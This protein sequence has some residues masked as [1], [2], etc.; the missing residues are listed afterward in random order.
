MYPIFNAE[1]ASVADISVISRLSVHR[2][3]K[4]NG[5]EDWTPSNFALHKDAEGM[6]QFVEALQEIHRNGKSMLHTY[7]GKCYKHLRTDEG[8]ALLNAA[9]RELRLR[10]AHQEMGEAESTFSANVR[11]AHFHNTSVKVLKSNSPSPSLRFRADTTS[12]RSESQALSPS[13]SDFPRSAEVA[14]PTELSSIASSTQT[15]EAKTLKNQTLLKKPKGRGK[16]VIDEDAPEEYQYDVEEFEAMVGQLDRRQFWR[17]KC[18]GRYVEDV[19]IKAARET[20]TVQHHIH[21][22]VIHTMDKHTRKLF[23]AHEWSEVCDTNWKPMPQP[24]PLI[25]KYLDTFNKDNIEELHKAA[26]AH[27][28]ITG[29]YEHEKHWIYRWI[30]ITIENWLGLYCQQPAPLKA[31]QQ[32]SFWRN[33]IFGMINSLFRDVQGMVVVHGELTS[34]DTAKRRNGDRALPTEGALERKRMGYR[35]DGLVQ[36]LGQ[37]PLN[38]G[39]LE[40]GKV[41][42]NTGS[43]FL[44]DT[45]KITRELHDMLRNRLQ[46]LYVT[47][48]SRELTLMGFMLSGPTLTTLFANSPG[49]YVVRVRPYHKEFRI[50]EDVSHFKLNLR[51]LKHLLIAKVVLLDAKAIIQEVPVS[52]DDEEDVIEE[53]D[54]TDEESAIE[55]SPSTPPHRLHLP[56][57]QTTPMRPK[58]RRTMTV[59]GER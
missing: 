49:G 35:C 12:T 28:P 23:T 40:A 16:A 27:L 50:A 51:I 58:K 8:K 39:V 9:M 52:W 21:S 32:E 59:V 56:P 47:T 34:E 55:R 44:L 13:A 57:L 4:T 46:G 43:K 42:D 19:L 5:P 30:R 2:F 33:D 1:S 53:G 11:T 48:R 36:V 14:I 18:S 25:V 22:L 31:S 7:A 3:F 54:V 17:L 29:P 20:C 24:S 6:E 26:D 37:Q 15:T 45:L 10:R 38:I 41:F